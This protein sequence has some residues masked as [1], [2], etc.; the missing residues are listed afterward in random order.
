MDNLMKILI[1]FEYKIENNEV[2]I[3]ETMDKS[4]TVI[5]IPE[6]IEGYPVTNIGEFAFCRCFSLYDIKIPKSVNNI[7]FHALYYFNSQY[8]NGE[9]IVGSVNIINNKFIYRNRLVR[10]IIYQIGAD[11]CCSNNNSSYILYLI[12]CDLYTKN[13]KLIKYD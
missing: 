10:K 8:I 7:D 6:F 5:D 11:H 1:M 4:L 12:N 13:F 9:K 2:T 3:I